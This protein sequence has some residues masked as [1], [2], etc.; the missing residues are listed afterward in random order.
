MT[1]QPLLLA[2]AL[3]AASIAG[4]VEAR[5]DN[6][7][8]VQRVA[9]L[10]EHEYVDPSLGRSI[11][12]ALRHELAGGGFAAESDEALA[13]ALTATIR[14]ISG[15]GH[16]Y[17]EVDRTPAAANAI[18]TG[19][20][21]DFDRRERERYYGPQLNFGFRKVERLDNNIGLLELS[22]FAPVDM[23]GDTAVAAMQFLANTE[24]LVIDL[25]GN[26]GGHGEMANLLTSYLFDRGQH[27]LSG[28]YARKTGA[29]TPQHTHPYVPGP[30]YG[31]DKPVYLL[32]SP[33]TFSAAEAFTYDLQALGRVTVVGEPSGGGA[34]P[35]EYRGVG[36]AL[37][38]WLETERSVNP[39][40]GGNWQTVGVQPDV[41][42]PAGKALETALAMA[43]EAAGAPEPP[44]P[45]GQP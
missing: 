40:T 14:D 31:S 7:A 36:R 25:R 35:F 41:A 11:A 42:V 33:R 34:N 30:R 22:V 17:V 44:Q 38:L 23:G 18:D 37:V 8:I 1:L 24:A 3:L 9:D 32:T 27:P 13:T 43:R 20:D 29:T 2:A 4:A 26:G 39:L 15:P 28:V 12:D 6:A 16:L 10:I 21:S 45:P 5:E 19:A